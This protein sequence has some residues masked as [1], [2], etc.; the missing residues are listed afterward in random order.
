MK[1]VNMISVFREQPLFSAINGVEAVSENQTF[2]LS[3]RH[4]SV[5]DPPELRARWFQFH[6]V[7]VFKN[8]VYFV[9]SMA[10]TVCSG[11]IW[12]D[13]IT[14]IHFQAFICFQLQHVQFGMLSKPSSLAPFRNLDPCMC[15]CSSWAIQPSNPQSICTVWMS[16]SETVKQSSQ[17]PCFR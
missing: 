9:N 17:L 11:V 15:R 4:P 2:G 12:W 14:F 10:W 7:P 6:R 16:R 5:L 3:V 1:S 13:P 8:W